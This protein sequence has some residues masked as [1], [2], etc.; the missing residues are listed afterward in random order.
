MSKVK[1][2]RKEYSDFKEVKRLIANLATLEG[3]YGVILFRIDALLL[4]LNISTKLD[5][6][7]L[8]LIVWL[9]NIILKVS[10]ELQ[11]SIEGIS[12]TK[13]EFSVYFYKVGNAGILSI[14]VDSYANK[15]LLSIEMD[16][17]ALMIEDHLLD[18]HY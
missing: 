14:I 12:Y 16:K 1:I 15:G 7:L 11:E 5:Q 18:S 2:Q 10:K 13:E 9:K 8:K 3:I 6:K 17:H 4:H